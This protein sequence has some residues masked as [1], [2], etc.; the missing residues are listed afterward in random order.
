[1]RSFKDVA[2]GIVGKFEFEF[3]DEKDC[4]RCGAKGI[5]L[6]KYRNPVTKQLETNWQPCGCEVLDIMHENQQQARQK[7]V[8]K[9]LS[10]FNEKSLVNP[11]IKDATFKTFITDNDD[12][13]QVARELHRYVSEWLPGNVLLYG[14]YGT[15]KSHLAISATK[16]AINQS[17]TALFIS[18]PKLFSKIKDTYNKDSDTTEE[19][20]ISLINSVDLLVLDDIG[21][22]SGREEWSQQIL[23]LILDGRQ[24]KRTIYTTNL[25]AATLE[26][27]IGGRNYDRLSDDLKKFS[28]VGESHRRKDK[29]TW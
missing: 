12:F 15:G 6:V 29:L 7:K 11:K 17:R 13:K 26:S 20:L 23:F 10:V 16:L 3:L 5:K 27:K 8:E 1:M 28:L 18:V 19:K 4:E 24:G 21:A 25:D 14:S 2:Q 22:E 9:R